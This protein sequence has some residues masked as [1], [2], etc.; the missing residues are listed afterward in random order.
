M[1]KNMLTHVTNQY[2]AECERWI[3]YMS[4]VIIY[5]NTY[6]ILSLVLIFSYGFNSPIAFSQ[7]MHM[8]YE[9]HKCL[10]IV[11]LDKS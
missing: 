1:R 7:G 11:K 9:Y 2:T 3:T 10:A 6:N 5:Y 4:I 8:E